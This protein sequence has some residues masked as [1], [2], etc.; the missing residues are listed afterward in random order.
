[1][2]F[3]QIRGGAIKGKIYGSSFEIETVIIENT[4]HQFSLGGGQKR[5]IYNG[6]Y[7]H[8]QTNPLGNQIIKNNEIFADINRVTDNYI[9]VLFKNYQIT[10]EE[11]LL[12]SLMIMTAKP[13]I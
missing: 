2:Y 6:S 3:K 13:I 10:P 12:F 1:M 7:Y 9:E 5:T 8:F 11:L 4:I